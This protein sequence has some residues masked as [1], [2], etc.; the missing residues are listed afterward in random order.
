MKEGLLYD[1]LN[2]GRV[3]CHV[4]AHQCTIP[5]GRRGICQVR[6]NRDGQLVTL[7]YGQVVAQHVDPVEKKPLFHFYPGSLTYSL[8]TPGCNVHCRF[9]Q[10]ATVS[11]MPRDRQ[12]I[13]GDMMSPAAVVEAAL[14]AG[15]HSI[16]FTYVEPTIFFE[17]ALDIARLGREAGLQI[18][19]VSNGYQT[20]ETLALLAPLVQAANI[21]LKAF[22]DRF[23]RK[24]V[25]ARLDPVLD[26]LR[27]LKAAGMWLEVTTLVIPGFND[28]TEELTALARFLADE[29]GVDTP[30]HVSRFFPAY[31]LTEVP[32]TPIATIERA[33]AI[34]LEQGLQYVYQG[35]T[36]G[37][38][39]E[40]TWCPACGSEL[41]RRWGFALQ[42]NRIVQGQCAVCH[43]AIAGRFGPKRPTVVIE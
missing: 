39:G 16:A 24:V 6:E 2:S 11:Q 41:I 29:L 40:Q 4:C 34:G 26:T 23:Y 19:L 13:Q 27:Y 30:W 25:G 32:P 14:E 9:C 3:H 33:R 35:N 36:L 21:D 18:I 22:S 31:K 12:Q 17:Y 8:A 15:C 37:S 28:S 20:R 1:R 5:A 43:A 10:N 42:E 38:M 7:V